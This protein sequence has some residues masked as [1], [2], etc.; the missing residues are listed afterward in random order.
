MGGFGVRSECVYHGL[1]LEVLEIDPV[2]DEVVCRL[3]ARLD[4]VRV[5]LFGFRACGEATNESDDDVLMVVRD[6]TTPTCRREMEACDAL[7]GV[8]AAMDVL[9]WS[10]AEFQRRL[11]ARASPPATV[12]REGVFLHDEETEPIPREE[13]RAILTT[14]EA[15]VTAIWR[16]LLAELE[17]V[18]VP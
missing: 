9:V 8:P 1:W 12:V 13:A 14:A 17:L 5:Y 16:F 11:T 2:F 7:W 3:V 6:A 10:E 15:T 18:S 4:S